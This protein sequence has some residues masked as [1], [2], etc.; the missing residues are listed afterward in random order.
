MK[1]LAFQVQEESPREGKLLLLCLGIP[2]TFLFKNRW[3]DDISLVEK[4][5]EKVE[6]DFRGQCLNSSH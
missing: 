1:D 3:Y 6:A 5:F 2:F 4:G